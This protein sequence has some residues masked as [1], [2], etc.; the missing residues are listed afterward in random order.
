MSAPA[1]PPACRQPRHLSSSPLRGSTEPPAPLLR[2]ASAWT[3]TFDS[4]KPILKTITSTSPHH[5]FTRPVFKFPPHSGSF[6]WVSSLIL[7]SWHVAGRTGL[8]DSWWHWAS[9][10]QGNHPAHSRPLHV[11][12]ALWGLFPFCEPRMNEWTHERTS[13]EWFHVTGLKNTQGVCE[14]HY[15]RC[16][17]NYVAAPC[18]GF[19]RALQWK[20]TACTKERVLDLD[21]SS[22]RSW[23]QLCCRALEKWLYLSGLQ[24]LI[25]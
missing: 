24:V 4:P 6:P 15:W 23:L 3:Q 17:L 12:R 18:G 11:C 19:Q 13:G 9:S 20:K 8:P 16:E 7:F 14:E 2:E 10:E 21:S 25:C 5:A 1:L 22:P